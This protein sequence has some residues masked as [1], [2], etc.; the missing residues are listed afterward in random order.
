MKRNHAIY[1]GFYRK[2]QSI[3]QGL[4]LLFKCLFL[5]IGFLQACS[6]TFGNIIISVFQWPMIFL[7]AVLLLYRLIYFP[8][9]LK[10][11]GIILLILFAIS[12]FISM[13]VN[14]QYGGLHENTRYLMFMVFQFGLLYAF[15]VE[16]DPEINRKQ[17]LFV[18]KLYLC[19]AAVLS[20]ASF[21]FMAIG[22]SKQFVPSEGPVYYIGFNYGRLFGAYWDP[23]I[24]ATIACLAV[25][26]SIYFFITEK[27]L[28]HR[29][30][31]V[32]SVLL[33]ISYI[34]FSD[35]RTGKLCLIV[36]SF[37]FFLF[38][39]V[40]HRFFLG[41]IK[42]IACVV[43]LLFVIS[44]LAYFV[45]KAIKQGYNYVQNKIVT[46]S[47]DS[48]ECVEKKKEEQ[49][50]REQDISSDPSNRRFDI[51]KSAVEL[52][53][54]SPIVGVSRANTLRFAEVNLPDTYIINNDHMKFDSLHNLFFEILASQGILGIIFFV[55]FAVWA[56]W[57]I[58]K[59]ARYLWESPHYK[60]F[61]LII[62]IMATVC[63]STL[64]MAEIVY[65]TSPISLMFWLGLGCLNHYIGNN[66]MM[67]K[68][69]CR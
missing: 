2:S 59:N 60:L 21:C 18:S 62:C 65:V 38:L 4:E 14:Y 6:L 54:A 58:I 43:V 20:L 68:T 48:D 11:R 35:S 28:F 44:S 7:G 17:M 67:Q 25:F 41:K 1:M 69:E 32:L 55:L 47:S 49:I 22:Y 46:M 64:V 16:R 13:L 53:E 61:A 42:Q 34:T 39:F 19:G 37:F 57:G 36:G 23:N 29:I 8:K 40:K 56:L 12:Y 15:D 31:Y 45:P 50:G 63:A 66:H 9:Y 5:I 30:V 27:Q 10:T 33:Q 3:L 51:W 26:L 24:A 52:F